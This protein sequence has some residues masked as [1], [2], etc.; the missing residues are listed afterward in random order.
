[1][2]KIIVTLKKLA[3]KCVYL[4]KKNTEFL[5][6]RHTWQNSNNF[7]LQNTNNSKYYKIK[8]ISKCDNTQK[9]KL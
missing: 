4:K 5:T 8:R 7:F 1:M 3:K 9:L 6:K 2:T